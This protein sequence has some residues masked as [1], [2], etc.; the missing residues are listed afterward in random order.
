LGI[1]APSYGNV[2]LTRKKDDALA[3][4]FAV[5]FLDKPNFCH[6]DPTVRPPRESFQHLKHPRS[7]VECRQQRSTSAEEHQKKEDIDAHLGFHL[8]E[9]RKGGN[10]LDLKVASHS[11]R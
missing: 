4:D 8:P 2:H 6:D 7:S 11:V 1:Y 9:A 5:I 3:L 10:C